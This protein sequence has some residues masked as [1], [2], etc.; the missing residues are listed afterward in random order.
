ML[1]QSV[2]LLHGWLSAA[3]ARVTLTLHLLELLLPLL[4]LLF[5]FDFLL[6]PL[7]FASTL[8]GL[9]AGTPAAECHAKM[10]CINE[11]G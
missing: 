2:R 10:I 9:H 5:H 3:C 8:L 4:F 11:C 6:L 7:L 1:D